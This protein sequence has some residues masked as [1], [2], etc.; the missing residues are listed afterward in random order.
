MSDAAGLRDDR[1]PVANRQ[2]V[3]ASGYAR[4][5]RTVDW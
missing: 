4:S 5:I 3:A 2:H 1:L